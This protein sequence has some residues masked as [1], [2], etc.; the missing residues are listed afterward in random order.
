MTRNDWL[1]ILALGLGVIGYQWPGGPNAL[2]LLGVTILFL[3]AVLIPEGA[4][5]G[6]R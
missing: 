6:E 4:D 1:L 5:H 2:W 3:A